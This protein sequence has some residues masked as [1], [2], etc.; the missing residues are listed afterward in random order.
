M[1]QLG[2]EFSIFFLKQA[3]T[4]FWK[5]DCPQSYSECFMSNICKNPISTTKYLHKNRWPHKG[6]LLCTSVWNPNVAFDLYLPVFLV[7]FSLELWPISTSPVLP[8]DDRRRRR[9]RSTVWLLWGYFQGTFRTVATR[10]SRSTRLPAVT[11]S[12]SS[13]DKGCYCRG[14]DRPSGPTANERQSELGR[15]RFDTEVIVTV[16]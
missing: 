4:L 14:R 13:T 6:I 9:A 11:P 16:L 15:Q 8:F 5:L 2:P 3:K 10:A 1:L 12:C 7:W